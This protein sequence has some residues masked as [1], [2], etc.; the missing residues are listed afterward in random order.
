MSRLPCVALG[1]QPRE[2]AANAPLPSR[3]DTRLARRMPAPHHLWLV[4]D[5]ESGT[6]VTRVMG[7]MGNNG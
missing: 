2:D 4:G 5:G 6:R 7:V 1:K 3:Q